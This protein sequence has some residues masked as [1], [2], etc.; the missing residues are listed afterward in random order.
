MHRLDSLARCL[1]NLQWPSYISP[2]DFTLYPQ[3]NWRIIPCPAVLMLLL[4][5]ISHTHVI[6]KDIVA[7]YGN[8]NIYTYMMESSISIYDYIYVDSH[9][10]STVEASPALILTWLNEQ[11]NITRTRN[12]PLLLRTLPNCYSHIIRKECAV[13]LLCYTIA[14]STHDK[15]S[16]IPIC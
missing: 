12:C 7:C 16:S 8:N 5:H 13:F 15:Y 10:G 14:F 1:L 4:C 11:K 9:N 6:S 2:I 3:R